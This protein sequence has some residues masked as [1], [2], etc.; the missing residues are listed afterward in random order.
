VSSPSAS[1][2]ASLFDALG[3]LVFRFRGVL[4]VPIALLAVVLSWR[5]HDRPGPGGEAVDDALN[6]LGLALC[7]LGAALR[8]VTI[9]QAPPGTSANNR[10]FTAQALNTTGP[11]AALRHPLYAGNALL[12]GG[13]LLIAHAPWAY[14][15]GAAA[16][17]LM[18]G[19]I[20]P[21]EERRLAERFGDAW[22]AWAAR[23]P[24]FFPRPSTLP[25][26]LTGPFAWRR[27]ARREVNTLVAWGLGATLLLG[28]EGFAREA[29]HGWR[30]VG[31]KGAL[32]VLLALWPLGKLLRHR[33]RRRDAR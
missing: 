10:E 2:A 14:A 6:G 33:A 18:L 29:L 17:A 1:R 8:F 11:Y 21:A 32:W 24:A 3:R 30:A 31:L 5:T 15:L 13:L 25:L 27:A 16:F 9:A 20:V 28:W 26:T 22:R 12:V 19:L 4:P 23:V 7:V